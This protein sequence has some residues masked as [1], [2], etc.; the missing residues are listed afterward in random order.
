M[1]ETAR[2]YLEGAGRNQISEWR[3]R[4]RMIPRAFAL[5]PPDIAE[6]VQREVYED[7]WDGSRR[8]RHSR[9]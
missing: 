1:F 9:R 2:R 5:Q 7:L 8:R 6:D 4:V 3:K